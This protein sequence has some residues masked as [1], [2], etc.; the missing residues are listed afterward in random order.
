MICLWKILGVFLFVCVSFCL[1]FFFATNESKSILYF[2][3]GSHRWAFLFLPEH[4]CLY[5]GTNCSRIQFH[6]FAGDISSSLV[7]MSEASCYLV[8]ENASGCSLHSEWSNSVIEGACAVF[9]PQKAVPAFKRK[10]AMSCVLYP[11]PYPYPYPYYIYRRVLI[12]MTHDVRCS[13]RRG[14]SRVSDYNE[15]L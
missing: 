10:R 2:L 4:D 11:Y 3:P 14:L 9:Y 6:F 8:Y 1:C 7:Q 5:C 13:F 12:L 15:W